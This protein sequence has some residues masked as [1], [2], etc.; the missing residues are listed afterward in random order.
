V[1]FSSATICSSRREHDE[2]AALLERGSARDR[3]RT[4]VAGVPDQAKRGARDGVR[5]ELGIGDDTTVALF[6]AELEPRKAPLV[7]VNST[8]EARRTGADLV[9]LVAGDGSQL[10]AVMDA[11]DEGIRVLGFRRD[12]DRLMAAADVF[13][14]PSTREGLSLALLEA[15]SR[16]LVPVVA[17]GP[18]NPEAVGDTG[19]VVAPGD[20]QALAAALAALAG[21]P[22]E[23]SRLGAAAR[24]RQVSEFG[25]DRFLR[26]VAGVYER[27]LAERR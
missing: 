10:P 20:V 8:L 4:I 27:A 25:V 17:A 13:V 23:R 26:E 24:E 12:L 9:L 14:L 18:G 19:I 16:S 7:A 2:L 1:R 11:A 6:A 5:K 22:E 3:L 21:D 15:M